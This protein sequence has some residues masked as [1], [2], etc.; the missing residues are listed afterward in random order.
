MKGAG[1]CLVDLEDLIMV[2]LVLSIGYLGGVSSTYTLTNLDHKTVYNPSYNLSC[3]EPV[4]NIDS[5][6]KI[7][8]NPNEDNYIQAPYT[9]VEY[10]FDGDVV[11]VDVTDV[12]KPEG[13]SM[14]PTIWTGN[15]L[16]MQDYDGGPI[17]AGQILRYRTDSGYVIHRIQANY[18][19]TGGYLLMRGD[20]NEGSSRISRKQVTHKVVGILYTRNDRGYAAFSD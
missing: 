7:D 2:L 5:R 14:R 6:V 15:T 19:E 11:T 3:P 8:Y 1:K 20:N 10:A 16:L 17:K 18:L 13:K 12:A 4:R 9:T